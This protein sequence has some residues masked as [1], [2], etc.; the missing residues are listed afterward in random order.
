MVKASMAAEA[1]LEP[2]MTR[3]VYLGASPLGGP[4]EQADPA[5]CAV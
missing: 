1:A 2:P 5:M 4:P 3:V